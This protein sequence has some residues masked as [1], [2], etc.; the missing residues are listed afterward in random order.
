MPLKMSYVFSVL[1]ALNKFN[2]GVKKKSVK[3]IDLTEKL[4]SKKNI[5]ID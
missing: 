2:G 5:L 4:V 1:Q 3:N